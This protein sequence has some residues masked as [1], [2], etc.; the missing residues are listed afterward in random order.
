MASL[1]EPLRRRYHK[2]YIYS[3]RTRTKGRRRRSI[4]M[5]QVND[6]GDRS[7]IIMTFTYH[8]V[9]GCSCHTIPLVLAFAF[10]RQRF[11]CLDVIFRQTE[12]PAKLPR[13]RAWSDQD[14]L[15]RSSTP[16]ER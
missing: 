2:A 9:L 10:K 13:R 1:A 15:R 5:R 7:Y 4:A 6:D 8:I 3:K 16:I 14:I 12:L 11:N